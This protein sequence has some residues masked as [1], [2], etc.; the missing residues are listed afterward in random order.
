VPL[1]DVARQAVRVVTARYPAGAQRLLDMARAAPEAARR[2]P[3]RYGPLYAALMGNPPL[4]PDE[5]ALVEAFARAWLRSEFDIHEVADAVEEALHEQTGRR[6]E[7]G[8]HRPDAWR[9]IAGGSST[10]GRL[11]QTSDN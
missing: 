11:F 4:P 3:T 5:A 9:T 6:Q 1:S 8:R 7:P 2:R 10:P